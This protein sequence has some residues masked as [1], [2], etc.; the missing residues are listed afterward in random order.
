MFSFL[1]FLPFPSLFCIFCG[2]IFS[3]IWV[4]DSDLAL[5]FFN[6]DFTFGRICSS[7]DPPVE[8]TQDDWGA[9]VC[10]MKKEK[11]SNRKGKSKWEW[12]FNWEVEDGQVGI[13][14]SKI[15]GN[16]GLWGVVGRELMGKASVGWCPINEVGV[17]TLT[18]GPRKMER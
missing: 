7:T 14:R 9:R 18:T 10:N 13:E 6:S 1:L 11:V 4:N 2:Y 8:H 16:G 12:P 5:N 17:K 3:L 15:R